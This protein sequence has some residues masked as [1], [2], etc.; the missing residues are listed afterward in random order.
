VELKRKSTS[1]RLLLI[2]R[3]FN[4]ATNEKFMK[5]LGISG[6]P[7][8]KGNTAYSV[9]YALNVISGRGVQTR[10]ISLAEK[11]I[12]PC[13]G[14]FE[15]VKNQKC[16]YC[17]DFS[18]I[19][20]AMKWCDGMILGSPVYLG[21]I[22][23]QLKIMMDRCVIFRSKMP[24]EMAGKIGGGIACG[25]F[26]NG[27][28]ELTLQCIHTFMLQLNM[29]IISDGQPFSHSGA[30]IVGPDAQKDELGL[31]TTKNLIENLY[32]ELKK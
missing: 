2:L 13:Q 21:L 11:N 18:E 30:A 25:D 31:Q 1:I 27:G 28:Q 4:Y 26:R 29:H 23:G 6:S 24:Y 12:H 9:N 5:I 3:K 22:T 19:N 7:R 14:C 17:D 10:Y 20:D 15:C 8:K 32:M 16:I